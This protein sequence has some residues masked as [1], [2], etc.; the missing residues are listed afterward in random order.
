MFQLTQESH[1]MLRTGEQMYGREFSHP[2]V[3]HIGFRAPVP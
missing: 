1:S 3:I 2:D